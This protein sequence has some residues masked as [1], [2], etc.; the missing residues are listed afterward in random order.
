MDADQPMDQEVAPPQEFAI[1][2]LPGVV[3][4]M[5]SQH[6]GSGLLSVT[7]KYV[8]VTHGLQCIIDT[9][10]WIHGFF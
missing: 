8:N 4:W 1:L 2:E 10:S 6:V 7:S 9:L 5:G 3:L